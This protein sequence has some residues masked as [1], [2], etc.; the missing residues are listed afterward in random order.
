M[1]VN[2]GLKIK[3]LRKRNKDTLKELATKIQYDYSNLSKVERG[4]YGASYDLLRRISIVYDINPNYFF[5]NL[6]EPE[7]KLLISDKLETEDLKEKYKFEVDGEEA[8]D[9]EIMAAIRLIRQLRP[10]QD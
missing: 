2:I 3:K 6:T 5:D 8:T 1:E 4:L 7:G 9:E 10:K